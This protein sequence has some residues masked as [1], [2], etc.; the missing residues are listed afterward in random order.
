[1]SF[2]HP[3]SNKVF[4]YNK[5][6]PCSPVWI[7]KCSSKWLFFKN[8]L[9]Q[10]SQ[11]KGLSAE[12]VFVCAVKSSLTANALSQ[13]LHEY[14]RRPV[15]LLLCLISWF[16]CWNDW[17]QTSHLN[18]F[19]LLVEFCLFCFLFLVFFGSLTSSARILLLQIIPESQKW[20]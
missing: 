13:I 14:G 3:Y 19:G 20:V 11:V 2:C 7:L 10:I 17:S 1:M 6:K 4:F 8:L 16:L 15:C 9:L 5:K 18:L 12:C